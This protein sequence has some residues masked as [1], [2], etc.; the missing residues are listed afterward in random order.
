MNARLNPW[1]LSAPAMVVYATFLVVP[2]FL[3]F[4]I[5]SGPSTTIRKMP[6]HGLAMRDST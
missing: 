2:L 6:F 5:S 1:L 3:V 4:L